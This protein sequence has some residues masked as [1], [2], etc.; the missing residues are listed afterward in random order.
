MQVTELLTG[1]K[2]WLVCHHIFIVTFLPVHLISTEN[3]NWQKCRLFLTESLAPQTYFLPRKLRRNNQL[4]S[5][6]LFHFFSHRNCGITRQLFPRFLKAFF[7]TLRGSLNAHFSSTH[8]P[9]ISVTHEFFELFLFLLLKARISH[10]SSLASY[11]RAY[12]DYAL[13][14]IRE[15]HSS[16]EAQFSNWIL[17]LF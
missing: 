5:G 2:Y 9:A 1:A 4:S 16:Q 8:S 15:Q 11:T 12:M 13:A 14:I 6:W 3:A 7:R 17:S 10:E